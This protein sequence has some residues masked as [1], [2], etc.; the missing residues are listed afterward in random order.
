MAVIN[1]DYI[2]IA[3]A[4]Y[5][6][7]KHM[8][9]VDS[10]NEFCASAQRVAERYLKAVL[11]MYPGVSTD[12]GVMRTRSLRVLYRNLAHLDYLGI[13]SA[14]IRDLNGFY[15]EASYP[16]DNFVSTTEEDEDL[17]LSAMEHIITH[18]EEFLSATQHTNK[19][20]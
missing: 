2:S 3:R 12:A 6:G 16:G 15:F 11:E 10:P 13:D 4:A 7:V 20:K 8:Y 9:R 1:N 19:F 17:C 14:R 5:R 18:V